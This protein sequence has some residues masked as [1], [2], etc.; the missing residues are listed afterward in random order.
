M[1]D[2]PLGSVDVLRCQHKKL[3]VVDRGGKRYGVCTPCLETGLKI[4][5]HLYGA[6][7]TSVEQLERLAGQPLRRILLRCYFC[8]GVLTENEK[9]RHLFHKEGFLQTRHSF[10]GRCYDC[11]SDGR[12]TSDE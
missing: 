12:G 6:N 2:N 11:Y 9:K 7:I 3:R 10:K 8:G 1:C 5:R 4:E